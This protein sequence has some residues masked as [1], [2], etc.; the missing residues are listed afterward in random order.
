MT[1]DEQIA[2]V[3]R[4]AAK[5]AQSEKEAFIKKFEGLSA[6]AAIALLAEKLWT[7]KMEVENQVDYNRVIG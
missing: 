7:L 3:A 4:V 1:E 2:T 5:E 6:R